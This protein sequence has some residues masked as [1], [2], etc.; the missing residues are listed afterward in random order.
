MR[1]IRDAVNIRLEQLRK[2]KT[3][4]TSLE[5]RVMLRAW[6]TTSTLLET[7][8]TELPTLLITS[9]VDLATEG[10][11]PS[12]ST[13]LEKMAIANWQEPDGSLEI[14]VAR[15]AGVKCPRCWRYVDS[16]ST[17]PTL[18]GLCKRCISALSEDVN[19]K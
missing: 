2:E 7:Y 6:G 4:G 19:A 8:R 14:N 17:E 10:E 11:M 18:E 15:V 5:A 3:V 16:L 13:T 12:K 9:Q 1:S